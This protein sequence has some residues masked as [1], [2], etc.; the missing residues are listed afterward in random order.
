MK[1]VWNFVNDLRVQ[2][3]FC[4]LIV[5]GIVFKYSIECFYNPHVN[6]AL[7]WGAIAFGMFVTAHLVYQIESGFSNL[8]KEQE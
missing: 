1:K 2:S 8:N 7:Y 5:Y 6:H 4:L 3:A